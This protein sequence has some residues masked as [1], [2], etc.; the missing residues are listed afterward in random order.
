MMTKHEDRGVPWAAAEKTETDLLV[1]EVQN[2]APFYVW[3]LL[4]GANVELPVEPG[5]G[6]K[7]RSCGQTF[8]VDEKSYAFFER[9]SRRVLGEEL[10]PHGIRQP[11]NA[12]DI[13][14]IFDAAARFARREL[15][16]PPEK[17]RV[18]FLKMDDS[19]C[20]F[21]RVMQ[22]AKAL[23]LHSPVVCAEFSNYLTFSLGQCYD[24][25]VAPRVSHPTTVA[26][27][28][29]LQG[30]GK[31]VVYET[32]D[33]LSSLPNWNPAKDK[34]C[35]TREAYRAHMIGAADGL[36]VSTP[37]LAEALGRKNQSAVCLNGIDTDLWPMKVQAQRQDDVRIIWAGSATHEADLELVVKPLQRVLKRYGKKVRLTFVGYA[38]PG[39]T[40]AY[41]RA[42]TSVVNI[43]PEWRDQVSLV[44]GCPVMKWPEHLAAQGANI[45]IAPLVDHEFNLCKSELKVLEAWALGIPVVASDIAPYRRA[46]DHGVN[47]R[48]V[49]ANPDLWFQELKNLIEDPKERERLAGN[50]LGKLKSQYAMASVGRSYE[51]ALIAMALPKLKRPECRAALEARKAELDAKAA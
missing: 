45:A 18:Y 42:G 8:T 24:V 12:E 5:G 40:C 20:G 29:Q 11:Y 43:S 34:V 17:L 26:I 15:K 13:V 38:P 41:E 32:D 16:I 23:A 44:R 48:L 1:P 10:E 35:E 37:E 50:G 7:I 39:F 27:L 21:Y 51:Q 46:L 31:S 36:I 2:R 25:I 47:G 28:K 49:P 4:N 3:R 9:I 14:R 33:L 30:V 22:P 6:V 19:G